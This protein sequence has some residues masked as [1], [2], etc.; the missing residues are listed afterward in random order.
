M[1][2]SFL[3]RREEEI[4]EA[5]VNLA[6]AAYVAIVAVLQE[7][8]GIFILKDHC[9]TGVFFIVDNMFL[10]KTIGFDKNLVKHG[11]TYNGLLPRWIWLRL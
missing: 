11:D 4:Q 7:P 1:P 9:I 3:S 6:A 2:I 10:L 5:K 8:D